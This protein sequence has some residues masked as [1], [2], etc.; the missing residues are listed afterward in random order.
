MRSF[1]FV[2]SIGCVMQSPATAVPPMANPPSVNPESF[3]TSLLVIP[4]SMAFLLIGKFICKFL[5]FGNLRGIF[6]LLNF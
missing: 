6:V 4:F 1:L 5:Q 3:N 2:G